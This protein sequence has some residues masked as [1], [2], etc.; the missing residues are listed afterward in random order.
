MVESSLLGWKPV[1]SRPIAVRLK[2]EHENIM[3]IQCYT[4][5]YDRKH[6][7]TFQEHFKRRLRRRLVIIP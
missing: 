1:N 4:L 7:E 2:V 6:E 5:I 3:L